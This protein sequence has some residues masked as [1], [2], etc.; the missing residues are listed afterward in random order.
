MLRA[1]GAK[2]GR[3]VHI[4]PSVVIYLPW[5]LEVHDFGAIGDGAF[6]YNLA[7]VTVGSRATI[8][9]R[10]HLCG[11]THDFT[12]RDFPLLRLPIKIGEQAWIGAD[13]FIGPGVTVNEGAVV[14]ARA[15]V[16]KDVAPWMVVVGNPAREVKRREIVTK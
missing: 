5:N 14:G 6:I 15:V 10:A 11:G 12:K 7:P 8:S 9:H 16:V 13:A 4:Y 3:H 1:F 2:I